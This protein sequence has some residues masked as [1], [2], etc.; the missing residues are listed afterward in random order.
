MAKRSS[1]PGPVDLEALDAFLL[2]DDAPDDSMGLSDLDGFLTGIVIGPE[3]I[4]PSEWLPVIWG[5]EE[6]AFAGIDQADAILGTILGRYNQIAIGLDADPIRFDPV[7]LQGTAE[8]EPAR[9]VP[10]RQA[11]V[12][13]WAAGFLDAMKLRAQAWEP[14]LRHRRAQLLILPLVALG[15][16][17]PDDLPFGAGPF[18]A[19]EIR[20][21]EAGAVE[22]IPVCVRGIHAFW[23][24]HRQQSAA[25]TLRKRRTPGSRPRRG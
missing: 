6:P 24:E 5:G 11:I 9:I 3:P 21:W 25:R 13:D 10:A 7:F 4:A 16:D 19:R 2:S 23:L 14:L 17:D 20:I 12:A 22:M 1:L 15:A 18:A 8:Q